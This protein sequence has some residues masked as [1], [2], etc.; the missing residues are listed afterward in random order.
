MNLTPRKPVRFLLPCR[1][2]VHHPQFTSEYIQNA[3]N[4][5]R[6]IQITL[7]TCT[8]LNIRDFI[9]SN[10]FTRENAN[11][12]GLKEL[13]DLM[14]SKLVAIA[15]IGMLEIVKKDHFRTRSAYD[16][17]IDIV[18][19]ISMDDELSSKKPEPKPNKEI[20]FND[21]PKK[22]KEGMANHYYAMLLLRTIKNTDLAPCDKFDRYLKSLKDHSYAITGFS[23][24]I[25]RHIFWGDMAYLESETINGTN[26]SKLDKSDVYKRYNLYKKTFLKKIPK[27]IKG[28]DSNK[29]FSMNAAYDLFF[30]ETTAMHT[31][32]NEKSNVTGLIYESWIATQDYPLADTIAN[33]YYR[34]NDGFVIQKSKSE[35]DPDWSTYF[36]YTDRSIIKLKAD[37]S[38]RL[39]NLLR[40]FFID[41]KSVV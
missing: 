12:Y 27:K 34:A 40:V 1:P 4:S 41:R 9:E 6:Q 22:R 13:I 10:I 7:D 24:D 14:H 3:K 2:T 33:I 25:A 20:S 35:S 38:G 11:F 30:T 31:S 29:Q 32:V 19:T 15:A 37:I 39:D 8:I 18:W 16:K 5:G 36:E 23:I 17:F 28:I 26:R 21:M